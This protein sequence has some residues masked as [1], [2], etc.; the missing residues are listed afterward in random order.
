MDGIEQNMELKKDCFLKFIKGRLHINLILKN[1]NYLNI[2]KK[3]RTHN[4]RK[5]RRN[6][7]KLT[8]KYSVQ[9]YN[10][11][12]TCFMLKLLNFILKIFNGSGNYFM[13]SNQFIYLPKIIKNNCHANNYNKSNEQKVMNLEIIKWLKAN[14]SKYMM[15]LAHLVS[16]KR[17]LF[18]TAKE[19]TFLET[20]YIM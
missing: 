16:E 1:K 14:C 10:I 18:P 20:I 3:S 6:I 5:N 11:N 2:S 13:E 19:F 7:L 17:K 9:D 15:S 4:L 12:E 8:D